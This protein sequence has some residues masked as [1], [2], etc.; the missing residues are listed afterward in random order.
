MQGSKKLQQTITLEFFC[1]IL[2]KDT[3]RLKTVLFSISQVLRA[4]HMCLSNKNSLNNFANLRA[5]KYEK[6][7]N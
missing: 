1:N 4:V 6:C 2:E 5:S 3:I 7:F